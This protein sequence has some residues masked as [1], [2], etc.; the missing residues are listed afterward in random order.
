M[1]LVGV[2]Q[3]SARPDGRKEGTKV[4]KVPEDVRDDFDRK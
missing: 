1:L 4:R 2:A 3:S